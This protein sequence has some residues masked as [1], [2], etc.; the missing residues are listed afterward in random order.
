MVS[1][2]PQILP[3]IIE[4]KNAELSLLFIEL[5]KF[6]PQFSYFDL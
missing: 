5:L 6:R 1:F 3:I 2:P 4:K